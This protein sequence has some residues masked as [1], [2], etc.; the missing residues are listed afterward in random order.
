MSEVH[1][2][3]GYVVIGLSQ[4]SVSLGMGYYLINRA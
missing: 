4:V 1:K 3:H 2:Y